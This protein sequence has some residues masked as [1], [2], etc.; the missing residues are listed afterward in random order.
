MSLFRIDDKKCKRD[1]I[2]VA[3][4]PLKI[5]EMKDDASLPTPTADA[6]ERCV[7]CGHCVAVCPHGAFTHNTLK[8]GDFS[9]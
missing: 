3:E 1:G 4:C 9:P 7:R 6:D 5:I 2:C 8:T